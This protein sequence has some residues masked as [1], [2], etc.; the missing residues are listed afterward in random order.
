MNLEEIRERVESSPRLAVYR[1][2]DYQNA[3]ILEEEDGLETLVEVPGYYSDEAQNSIL[4]LFV[5]AV[6]DRA[7]LLAAL[8]AICNSLD[9][10]GMEDWSARDMADGAIKKW[11]RPEY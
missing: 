11:K 1:A 6:E 7:R 2:D 5:N 10:E 3:S 9:A 8:D 4:D